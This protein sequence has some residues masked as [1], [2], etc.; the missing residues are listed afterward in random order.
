MCKFGGPA[1]GWVLMDRSAVGGLAAT[2]G[3]FVFVFLY[4]FFN[5]R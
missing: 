1:C 5:K 2:V 4:I 3:G